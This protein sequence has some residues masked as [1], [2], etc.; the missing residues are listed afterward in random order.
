MMSIT[1]TCRVY[2]A[3]YMPQN[4]DFVCVCAKYTNAYDKANVLHLY[5]TSSFKIGLFQTYTHKTTHFYNVYCT[6]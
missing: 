1:R 3:K 4:V 2:F 5:D 6:K